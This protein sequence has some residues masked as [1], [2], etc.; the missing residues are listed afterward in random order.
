MT[1]VT[2]GMY[3]AVAV[4]AGLGAILAV[5]YFTRE[6]HR[7]SLPYVKRAE[8][9]RREARARVAVERRRGPRRQDEVASQFVAGLAKRSVLRRARRMATRRGRPA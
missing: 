5:R 2:M 8:R 1:L 4:A 7:A 6:L 9:D 3:A